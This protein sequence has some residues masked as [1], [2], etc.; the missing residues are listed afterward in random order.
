MIT[1]F[2]RPNANFWVAIDEEAFSDY[3]EYPYEKFPRCI[4]LQ[5]V[6]YLNLG[7]IRMEL[8]GR[9]GPLDK[10]I[11]VAEEEFPRARDQC[12]KNPISEASVVLSGDVGLAL[13]A[14]IR[15]Y[16]YTTGIETADT[17]YADRIVASTGNQQLA[18][19]LRQYFGSKN[20]VGLEAIK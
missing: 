20:W 10:L 9:S 4:S 18:D 19:Y 6:G 8:L 3:E 13:T 5:R 12:Y 17:L 2:E 15:P 11:V 16:P 7:R 14:R 1:A